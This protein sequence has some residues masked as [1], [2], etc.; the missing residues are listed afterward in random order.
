MFFG[1]TE[2]ERES[3]KKIKIKSLKDKYFKY[4]SRLSV[5]QASLLSLAIGIGLYLLSNYL[6]RNLRLLKGRTTTLSGAVALRKM[7]MSAFSKIHTDAG[8]CILGTFFGLAWAWA[9]EQNQQRP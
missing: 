8:V 6:P 5:L 9:A 4:P 7:Y 3:P 2:R 1:E